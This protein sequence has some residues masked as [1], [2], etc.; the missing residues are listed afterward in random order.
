MQADG[1]IRASDNWQRGMTKE[2][3]IK[4][5]ER[6]NLHWWLRHR[7]YP[8]KDPKAEPSIEDDL[9]A[10]IFNASGYL[11]ELLKE[12]LRVQELLQEKV[13]NGTPSN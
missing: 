10:I 3:Y 5:G 8:V 1:A 2:S 7:G 4:G 6:H 13:K 9:C 12:K 11:H